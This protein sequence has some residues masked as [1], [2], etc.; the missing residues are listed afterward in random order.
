MDELAR[1]HRLTAKV[2][3]HGMPD[4]DFDDQ[5]SEAASYKD[6]ARH[7]AKRM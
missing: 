7:L 5:T 1:V 4:V 3:E 2:L 6:M